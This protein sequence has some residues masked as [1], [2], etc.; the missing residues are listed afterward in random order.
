MFYSYRFKRRYNMRD[1]NWR[2]PVFGLN[3]TYIDAQQQVFAGFG[4][5]DQIQL[6]HRLFADQQLSQPLQRELLRRPAA[7]GVLIHDPQQ[8]CFLLIEQFRVG[9][10][11]DPVSAWQLEVV[12]GL[13][14]QGESAEQAAIREAHEET[15]IQIGQLEKIHHFYPSVGGC[16]EQFTLYAALADL[17]GVGGI[18]GAAD[19]GENILLHVIAYAELDLL[20]HSDR[21][22]NAPLIIALQWLQQ[23]RRQ[24]MQQD[25]PH[26]TAQVRLHE[27]PSRAGS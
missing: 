7:V 18:Y 2:C 10:I 24:A 3:D 1:P 19:E 26:I 4:R 17:R 15:G 23:Q 22:R 9:A 16:D 25:T 5:I 6:R 14:D 13:V 8:Q 11:A 12:A 20:L 21:L 27:H